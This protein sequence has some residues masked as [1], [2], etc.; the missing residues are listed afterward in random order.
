MI[1][2][3]SAAGRSLI[4]LVQQK[5]AEI[6]SEIA[7]AEAALKEAQEV[8]ACNASRLPILKAHEA[9][10]AEIEKGLVRLVQV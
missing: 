1:S 8:M 4:D 9:R 3:D 7:R 2:I 6:A 10:W 5:R